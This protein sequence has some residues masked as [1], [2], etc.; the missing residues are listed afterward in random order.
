MLIVQ[1]A[2]ECMC[3]LQSFAVQAAS[4]AVKLNSTWRMHM[5]YACMHAEH[6]C[7]MH[8]SDSLLA[9]A[10]STGAALACLALCLLP[11]VRA[12]CCT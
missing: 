8:Y 9:A 12:A 3:L 7:D 6:N 4:V 2:N 5:T 1:T 11:G 10:C